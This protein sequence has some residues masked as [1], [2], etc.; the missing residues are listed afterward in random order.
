[1][2]I[3]PSLG[4]YESRIEGPCGSRCVSVGSDAHGNEHRF[5]DAAS[6]VVSLLAALGAYEKKY[7]VCDLFAAV[8]GHG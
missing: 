6:S 2:S 8:P 7:P 4:A 3:S 1:M 5:A